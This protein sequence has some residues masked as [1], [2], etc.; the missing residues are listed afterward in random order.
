MC[1]CID[2]VCTCS[3]SVF[4]LSISQLSYIC[5]GTG[6]SGKDLVTTGTGGPLGIVPTP[7]LL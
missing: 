1:T 2:S 3:V 6:M 5:V 4:L 7:A